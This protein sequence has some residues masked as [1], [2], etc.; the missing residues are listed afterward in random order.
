[1]TPL[2]RSAMVAVFYRVAFV[3]ALAFLAFVVLML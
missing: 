3:A 2:T 1:M